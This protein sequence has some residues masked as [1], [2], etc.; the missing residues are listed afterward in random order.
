VK[1]VSWEWTFQGIFYTGACCQNTYS[2][3]FL[4]VSL[5]LFRLN[6]TFGDVKRNGPRQILTVFELLWSENLLAKGPNMNIAI[7]FKELE[8]KSSPSVIFFSNYLLYGTQSRSEVSLIL[9]KY[10]KI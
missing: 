8:A 5:S 1:E 10:T 6:I 4:F 3:F 9:M 7:I 2:K